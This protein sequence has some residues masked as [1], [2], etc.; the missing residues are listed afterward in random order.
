MELRLSI[1]VG[2]ITD[3]IHHMLRTKAPVYIDPLCIRPAA[4]ELVA[5]AFDNF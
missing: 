4:S 1:T 3:L 2:E 5:L